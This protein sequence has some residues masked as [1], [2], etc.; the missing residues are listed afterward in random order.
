MTLNWKS[1][2]RAL[3]TFKWYSRPKFVQITL[4]WHIRSVDLATSA[5]DPLQRLGNSSWELLKEQVLSYFVME[6]SQVASG[7]EPHE[8]EGSKVKTQTR[9]KITKTTRN[10]IKHFTSQTLTQAIIFHSRRL[11]IEHLISCVE[12]V[13]IESCWRSHSRAASLIHSFVVVALQ[14]K[15]SN[16]KVIENCV[17]LHSASQVCGTQH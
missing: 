16:K 7:R 17:F 15:G 14:R 6:S 12:C 9:S 13:W 4:L 3:E 2:L 5:S 10:W 1:R 11:S 8:A